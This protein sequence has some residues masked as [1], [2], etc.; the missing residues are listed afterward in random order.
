MTQPVS[1]FCRVTTLL[2]LYRENWQGGNINAGFGYDQYSWSVEGSI[3]LKLEA[4]YTNTVYKKDK[5]IQ[6]QKVPQKDL[7]WIKKA[8]KIE[9]L[10]DVQW[11]NKLKIATNFYYAIENISEAH[12]TKNIWL[13]DQMKNKNTTHNS[14]RHY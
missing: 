12:S 6:P 14:K 2:E 8:H 5:F 10:T 3:L 4:S 7:S 1:F 13:F 9:D 11:L